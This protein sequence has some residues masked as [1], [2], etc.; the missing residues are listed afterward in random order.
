MSD[1]KLTFQ[2]HVR[3]WTEYFTCRV[4]SLR[5]L[6]IAKLSCNHQ[7]KASIGN[8]LLI[9]FCSDS[10]DIVLGEVACLPILMNVTRH[11][12][13]SNTIRLCLSTYLDRKWYSTMFY[14]KLWGLQCTDIDSLVLMA[15]LWWRHIIRWP[16]ESTWSRIEVGKR[17]WR[18]RRMCTY[19]L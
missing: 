3:Y 9:C 10:Q 12:K 6:Q 19:V 1:F 18:P 4:L 16:I 2:I 5:L 11:M 15:H 17:E 14:C 7:N 8:V 13:T